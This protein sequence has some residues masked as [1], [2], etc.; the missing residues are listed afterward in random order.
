MQPGNPMPV[1]TAR[2]TTGNTG[3]DQE[4]GPE[5]LFDAPPVIEKIALTAIFETL[6]TRI[7]HWVELVVAALGMTM[8][9]IVA[10]QVF[11]R[12]ALNHSL[13][14]SEELA[15]FL[16]VWLTFLGA[17]VAYHRKAHPGIDL[18]VSFL[19]AKLRRYMAAGVHGVTLFLSGVMIISG[20][21]FAWFVRLQI[22]PAL[23][24][25]KWTVMAIIPV[26][27]LL[28]LIHAGVFLVRIFTGGPH[29][30]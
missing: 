3:K 13:F 8:T 22:S 12:Y 11:C 4:K 16:L 27:G 10:L 5:T 24:L 18:F 7:N 29:D 17:S 28:L 25:P 1:R 21:Q 14:W 2:D 23:S 26:S 9:V 15:R 30:R 19:P 6:S 20:L